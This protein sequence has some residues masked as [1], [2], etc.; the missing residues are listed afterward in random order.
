MIISS[1]ILTVLTSV[2]AGSV[3]GIITNLWTKNKGSIL[4]K[5]ENISENITRQGEDIV[6]NIALKTHIPDEAIIALNEIVLSVLDGAEKTLRAKEAIVGLSGITT[7][8]QISEVISQTKEDVSN[9]LYAS[10]GVDRNNTSLIAG[11]KTII[12][13]ANLSAELK[14]DLKGNTEGGAKLEIPL[15]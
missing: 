5:V 9:A 14:T 4:G 8:Q 11:V 7:N 1:A 12:G 3:A 13:I 15:S 2:M 6:K 10:V